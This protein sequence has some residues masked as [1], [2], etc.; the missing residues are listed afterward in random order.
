MSRQRILYRPALAR[1]RA[2]LPLICLF[3]TGRVF[4]RASENPAIVDARITRAIRCWVVAG[5]MLHEAGHA[6]F[7]IMD[8][9][10]FGRQEDAA[11]QM[12][13]FIALQFNKET[14]RTVIKGFAYSWQLEAEGGADPPTTLPDPSDPNYPSDPKQQCSLDPLCA[15]SDEHGT[16]SQRVYNTLCIAYGGDQAGFQDLVDSGW[17]P[18]QRA[19]TCESEYQQAKFAFEK[20][21]LPAIDQAQMKRVQ[22]Q[23]WFYPLEAP[24]GSI[25]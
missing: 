3:K 10:M 11:D 13:G 20:T 24:E 2:L 19:K 14:A 7:D 12:A 25:R 18:E 15:F 8:V 5:V 23:R 17:L 4:G 6:L 9:P 1:A 21:V 22:N 16:A